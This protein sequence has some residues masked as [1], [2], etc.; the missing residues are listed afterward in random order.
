MLRQHEDT[1]SESQHVREEENIWRVK[2]KERE[3]KKKKRREK[4]RNCPV[5]TDMIE[6]SEWWGIKGREG[7]RAY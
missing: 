4:E 7:G 1:D 3:S 2:M 5:G 6:R